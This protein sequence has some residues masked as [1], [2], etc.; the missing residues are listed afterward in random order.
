[1]K[2]IAV[3]K[4]IDPMLR[5]EAI[6]VGVMSINTERDIQMCERFE[7]LKKQMPKMDCYARLSYEYRMSERQ[8]RYIIN[9]MTE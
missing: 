8:A 1:M 4:Q 9:Q 2:K 5:R 6:R 3:L 7:E